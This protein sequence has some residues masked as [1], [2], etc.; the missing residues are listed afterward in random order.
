MGCDIHAFIEYVYED[1]SITNTFCGDEMCFGRDYDLFSLLAG[2]RGLS[3][4]FVQPRGFPVAD[5]ATGIYAPNWQV[6]EKYS[7]YGSD[8]H[9][10]TW[11][12]L[13]ELKQIRKLYIQEKVD[14]ADNIEFEVQEM[15]KNSNIMN[16]IFTYSF[17]ELENQ[18]LY[19]TIAIMESLLKLNP[20]IKTRLVCWFDS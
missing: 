20:T 5:K 7:Q 16:S 17:G 10:A 19:L 12:T 14:Y 3:S 11:L 2:V 13:D 18:G 1:D 15:V 9:S 4:P 6:S 8:A